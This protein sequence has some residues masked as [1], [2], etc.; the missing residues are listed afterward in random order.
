MPS[1]FLLLPK[2]GDN[3]FPRLRR[4]VRLL[5]LRR[6]LSAPLDGLRAPLMAL[7][8]RR[9]AM[10]MDAVGSPDVLCALLV[11]ER[12]LR[13]AAEIL[14]TLVPDLLAALVPAQLTEALLW[15]HPIHTVHAPRLGMAIT[16][17][18]PARAMLV[19][20]AGVSFALHD[21]Q[22]WSPDQPPP[23]GVH[24]QTDYHRLHPDLPRLHLATRDANPLAM[25]EAHPDK[26]GNA[27]A[28]GD[29]SVAEWQAG[30]GEALAL[31]EV[32]LP[33]WW[34]E[35]SLSLERLLPVGFEPEL[36]LSASYQE[37]PNMAYLTLHPNPLTLAEAI[38]HETQHGR[39]NTL[40]WL[41]P[42]LK[43]GHSAWTQ[44]P[45]RPDMRPLSGVLLAAHAFVP[46]SALHTQLL[47]RQHPI[48]QRPDFLQRRAAVWQ[49]ND[50]AMQTLSSMAEPTPAGS[51]LLNDLHRLHQATMFHVEHQ[52]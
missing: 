25:D 24:C 13:P 30:L 15:N 40:M 36:H 45:V 11:L 38:I 48:T 33:A 23:E 31:I 35:L 14:P 26:S 10:L 3:S 19:D 32:G 16:F 6:L 44:S 34:Q 4:K 7:A 52:P 2:A 29:R 47:H 17:S 39:L 41:D 20:P 12:G 27:I 8:Q 37:A 5:A 46:V 51:R 50:K 42:V 21:G 49:S 1:G 9:S 43:N 18:P 22:K 28:L